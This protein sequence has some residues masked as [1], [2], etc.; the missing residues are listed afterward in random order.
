MIASLRGEIID[1]DEDSLVVEVGG[2]GY[3]VYCPLS[4]MQGQYSLNTEIFLFTHL[5]VREDQWTLFGFTSQEE[6]IL[7]RH[8]LG[9]SGIGGKSALGILNQLA[10]QQIA[11]AMS[12]G[13]SRPFERVSGIGKKTAQRLVLELKDKIGKLNIAG[14]DAADLPPETY[15]NAAMDN[16]AIA[17]LCQLGYNRSEA[18]QAVVKILS[19]EPGIDN[20]NLLKKA[21]LALSR[22]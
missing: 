17:A 10:P 3:L 14:G 1:I 13:D 19:S 12:A 5:V 2:V 20:D 9:V 4:M 18:K 21:L 22:F 16:D 11:G 15:A 6:L 8:F 7:F